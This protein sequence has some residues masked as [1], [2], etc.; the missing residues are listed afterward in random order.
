MFLRSSVRLASVALALVVLAPIHLVADEPK[1]E[2]KGDMK[3]LQGDWV[4][5]DDTGES[6]WTFKDDKLTLKT[7]SRSYDIVVKVDADAKPNKTMELNVTEASVN[8]KGFKGP[9]IYKFDGDKAVTICFG[10]DGNRPTEYKTD[11]QTMF[12][13]DL[14]K[15]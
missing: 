15:K 8:A 4:S 12:S 2:L 11:F 13:F 5:K 14:K 9:A 1:V 6:T 10:A 3:M 7:P